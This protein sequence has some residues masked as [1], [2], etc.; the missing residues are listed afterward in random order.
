MSHVFA[1]AGK[2][3]KNVVE[4]MRNILLI[5]KGDSSIHGFKKSLTVRGFRLIHEKSLKKAL[6]IIQ[7]N[8]L[9]LLVID[10]SLARSFCSSKTFSVAAKDIPKLILTSHEG[11]EG[12]CL[13]LDDRSAYPVSSQLSFKEFNSWTAKILQNKTL[14]HDMKALRTELTIKEKELEF[15]DNIT[16]EINATSDLEKNLDSILKKAAEMTGARTGFILLNDAVL[17]EIKPVRDSK[18][19]YRVKYDRRMSLIR[20]VMEKGTTLAVHDVSEEKRY[21][22]KA[23]KYSRIKLHSLI[24]A[25]LKLNN[26]VIGATELIN[27]KGGRRFTEFDMNILISASHYIAM[28]LKRTLL[29]YRIEEISITDDLTSVY[30]ARYLDQAIEIE[31]EKARRYQSMFSLIFM[32]IDN[33]KKVNDKHGH[34][35][36]SRVLIEMSQLLGECLRKV[37]VISRYGGDEFVIILPHTS[38]EASF[39]VAERLRTAIE[40]HS[41]ITGEN[42]SLKLTASFGI[43]SYPDNAKDKDTLLK[44]ADSAMYHGKFSTKNVVFAAQESLA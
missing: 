37:D 42:L 34:L 13:W 21:N 1:E 5:D 11:S 15:I 17:S 31:I 8:N 16:K 25:P 14:E 22:E 43:A 23:D 35:V 7:K 32:D 24:C 27:K 28:T 38:R 33:F 12:S 18:N 26:N 19:I 30:N 44:L 4:Q 9:E 36:G 29:Y 20:W 10:S 41:F 40:K 3:I 2:S 6:A 39:L